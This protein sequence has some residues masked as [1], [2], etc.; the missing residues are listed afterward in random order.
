[1]NGTLQGNSSSVVPVDSQP[2]PITFATRKERNAQCFALSLLLKGQMVYAHAGLA[3]VFLQFAA[4]GCMKRLFWTGD[5][6]LKQSARGGGGGGTRWQ[7]GL[8]SLYRQGG[9]YSRTLRGSQAASGLPQLFA[10]LEIP[11]I[12]AAPQFRELTSFN[13]FGSSHSY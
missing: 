1:M 4:R 6:D 7:S 9:S 8:T 12:P 3:K 5:R 11:H 2:A 13:V 10:L